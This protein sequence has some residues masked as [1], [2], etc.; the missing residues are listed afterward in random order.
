MRN[1]NP[2]KTGVQTFKDQLN[3]DDFLVLRV[4]QS[5]MHFIY[6]RLVKHTRP[7]SNK[8]NLW[9]KYKRTSGAQE[10]CR[11]IKMIVGNNGRAVIKINVEVLKMDR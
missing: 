8:F 2:D 10:M 3:E 1:H 11:V 9:V 6:N 7:R 5:R 4:I